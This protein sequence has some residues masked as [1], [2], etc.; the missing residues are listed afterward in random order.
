MAEPHRDRQTMEGFQHPSPAVGPTC[1]VVATRSVVG[2]GPSTLFRTDHWLPEGRIRD[3]APN[4]FG[5]IPGCI[6][7]SRFVREGLAGGWITDVPP[8]LSRRPWRNF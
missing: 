7:K 6:A 2:D 8:D 4:L 5:D 1:F 3:L